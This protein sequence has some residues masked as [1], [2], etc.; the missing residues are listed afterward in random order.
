LFR[1]AVFLFFGKAFK[2]KRAEEILV[3][4]VFAVFFAF[5]QTGS[6][7]ICIIIEK[8]LFLDKIDEHKAVQH[9]GYIPP[10]KLVFRNAFQE[11]QELF[12]LRL[13]PV[14]K[15]LCDF[16]YIKCLFSAS[17]YFDYGQ[18][19]LFFKTEC[20]I[21]DFLDKQIA[22]LACIIGVLAALS[23]LSG[24]T[25]YPLPDLSGLIRIKINDEVFMMGFC[26]LPLNLSPN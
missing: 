14:I 8:A 3:I 4:P 25:F 12:V 24:L 20:Q 1:G 18:L 22:G 13:E 9:D 7:V 2:K 11:F 5:A 10:L 21:I 19:F 23:R 6:Q 17:A 26:N 15:P 16:F